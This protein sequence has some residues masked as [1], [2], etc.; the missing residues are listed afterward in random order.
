[1]PPNHLLKKFTFLGEELINKK[2]YFD[3]ERKMRMRMKKVRN[4]GEKLPWRELVD[5][6]MQHLQPYIS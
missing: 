6:S 3:F 1:M 4:C 5:P 2:V